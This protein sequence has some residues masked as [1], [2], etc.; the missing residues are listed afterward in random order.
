[1]SS[2]PADADRELTTLLIPCRTYTNTIKLARYICGPHGYYKYHV[3]ILGFEFF[4][5]CANMCPDLI[6]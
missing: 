1:M 2:G 6:C 5:A 3:D 4:L